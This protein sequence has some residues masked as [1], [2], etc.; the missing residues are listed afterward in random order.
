MIELFAFALLFGFVG[1]LLAV[2][3]AAISGVLTRYAIQKYQASSLYLG[4]DGEGLVATPA[5]VAPEPEP[6]PRR[7]RQSAR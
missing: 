7:R 5:P 2:P 6:P 3:L 1:L 4:T